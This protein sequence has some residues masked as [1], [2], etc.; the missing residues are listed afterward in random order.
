MTIALMATTLM[1]TLTLLIEEKEE[2]TKNDE[3]THYKK[4]INTPAS[5]EWGTCPNC[6]C[7][8]FVGN[9]CSERKEDGMKFE[10]HSKWYYNDEEGVIHMNYITRRI[11]FGEALVSMVVGKVMMSTPKTAVDNFLHAMA[12]ASSEPYVEH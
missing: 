2:E 9:I 1:T 6:K 10:R 11:I 12:T 4:R 5:S 3:N 8:D 7:C